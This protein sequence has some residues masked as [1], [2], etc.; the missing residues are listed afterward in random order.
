MTIFLFLVNI[1]IWS[2]ALLCI[3]G[4]SFNKSY[5]SLDLEV[6]VSEEK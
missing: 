1:V 5:K 4:K 2:V 6:K 3:R